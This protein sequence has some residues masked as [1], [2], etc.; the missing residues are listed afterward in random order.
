MKSNTSL[1]SLISFFSASVNFL[2]NRCFE[3]RRRIAIP[4]S[5]GLVVPVLL[6]AG[7]MAC[8]TPEVEPVQIGENDLGGVVAGADGPE[9]GVW[10]IAET[11]DLPTRFA[12]IVVTDDHGRYLIPDLPDANYQVWV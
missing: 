6:F 10:V 3:N 11:T 12:K 5:P 2:W 8:T 7:L 9:A 1:Q 4:E